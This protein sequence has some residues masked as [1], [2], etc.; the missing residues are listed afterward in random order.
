MIG[1][2]FHVHLGISRDGGALTAGELLIH[3]KEYGVR[4]AV[5][6]PI[7]EADTGESYEPQNRKIMEEAKQHPEFIPFCRLNP[8][9]RE[10]ALREL[11]AC[12]RTGFQG[13]KLHPR[14]EAILP[15]TIDD[16]LKKV[17][18]YGWPVVIHV[19]HEPHCHPASWEESFRRFPKVK[20]ILAHSGKDS[21]EEAIRVAERCPNTFLD[22]STISFNRTKVIVGRLGPSRVVFASDEPY[23]HIALERKKFE[24]ICGPEELRIIF[25]E[26]PKRFFP[27]LSHA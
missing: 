1:C 26:N 23:S 13:L 5:V 17:D 6:F 12:R 25:E 24:L 15:N 4:R 19:S 16:I 20:F 14:A 11:E 3:M 21:Y 7:D 27:V 10:A 2:D 8:A 18:A 9:H 22:T